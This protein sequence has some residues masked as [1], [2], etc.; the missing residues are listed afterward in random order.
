MAQKAEIRS[1]LPLKIQT[2]L[3]FFWGM[4][5]VFLF[6]M[7]I[8][9]ILELKLVF[10]NHLLNFA[11][12]DVIIG[13]LLED[14]GWYF[15]FMGLLLMVH[16]IVSLFSP[17]L[18]RGLT[19]SIFVLT[20][21]IHV[22]LISYF[23]KTLLPLGSDVYAYSMDDLLATV[24]ASGQLNFLTVF[25][26]IVGAILLGLILSLGYRFIKLSLKSYL[27]VS[28]LTYV[29]IFFYVF[30]PIT[31]T[32]SANENKSNVQVNKTHFL[33]QASFNYFMF[34]DNY[35]FDFYLRPSGNDLVVKK[36]YFDDI[37]P[38]VH[39]AEYPDV[40]SPYFDSL[41]SKPDI[42][43]ILFE[44]L[45]R[46]Y[47][48]RD[49]YLGSFTPFLDSLAKSSLVWEN[50]ISSTGRT[51]GI[52][53]G[54]MAG[55]PFGKNGFLEF[56]PNYPHHET[57]LSILKENGYE[58]NFFIGADQNFDNEG[59][60]LNYQEVDLIVDQQSYGPEYEK[61]P[62]ESGFSWGYPDKAMFSNGLSKLP[63]SD[64]SPQLRIFQ[65]QTS[66][67]PYIVPNPEIY[68]PKL[69]NYL[70]N[71]LGFSDSKVSDY[72]SYENIYMTLLYAD[73]AVR[74]FFN[75]Y[76]KRPEFENTIFIIT[77]DHRLPEIPMATRLDRFRVPLIIYSPKLK[78]PASFKG[79][80]SHWEITPSIL[81]F[82]EKQVNVNLP[83]EMIW[84]GQVLDTASTF[85]SN[86]AMPLMRNKNQ[87]LD[88][89]HGEYFLSD[90]QLFIVSDGLNID[91][92]VDTQNLNRMTG[93]FEEFKNRNNYLIQTNKL[94]PE[95]L[96]EN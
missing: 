65:T 46:A 75:E 50:A 95:D 15:Y 85:Q 93:E 16:L 10:D 80:V 19:L 41:E 8:I 4:G 88:Y 20:I 9:R 45:G 13:S 55:L 30:F 43:F 17:K 48:G 77:G 44:S 71:E 96:P 21:I 90:G 69:R 68:Q 23:L 76:R 70:S 6:L 63:P 36:D 84:Q 14:V 52:L 64:E 91:P 58:L 53:P 11:I 67:D 12:S 2:T 25:L 87:L 79:V 49:A 22:A 51:F 73:D 94:L 32:S 31:D 33:T 74:D 5:I 61:T 81:S 28:G 1:N 89:I 92:I 59:S 37:Y 24:Q 27:V 62:S 39:R 56:S 18:G 26:G 78:G 82:L 47:S 29:F 40:L 66:H 34:D 54:T 57:I 38:F 83:E 42:V 86:I 35:Y 7:L 72:L 60:F 3:R